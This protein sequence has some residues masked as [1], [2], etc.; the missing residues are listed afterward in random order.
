[1]TLDDFDPRNEEEQ[2]DPQPKPSWVRMRLIV[3]LC[4][5]IPLAIFGFI[6]NSQ[7]TTR[8]R[9]DRAL[10]AWDNRAALREI[11][12]FEDRF[13][14]TAETAFLQ[15]RAYRHLGDDRSFDRYSLLAYQ[16][17]YPEEKIK[18]ERMLREISVGDTDNIRDSMEMV[19]AFPGVELEEVGPA[20]MYGFLSRLD[21]SGIE[22]FLTFWSKEE[23]DS[24]WIP[25]FHGMALL[26]RR[27]VTAAIE[28][29]EKCA[30]EHPDFVPVYSQLGAAYVRAAR[31]DLGIATL[32][33]YLRKI[34][35]DPSAI[36]ALAT[37]LASQDQDQEVIDLLAPLMNATDLLDEARVSLSRV[38][39]KRRKWDK[40]I[41]ALSPLA[42]SW[43]E[44]VRAADCLSQAHQALGNDSEA[45]S[46]AKIAHDGRSELE[47]VAKR[48]TRIVNGDDMEPKQLYELGHI[49][50]HKMSREDGFYW[51]RY[52]LSIDATY[53][54]AHEDLVIFY[55]RTNQPKLAA[56]HQ[57]YID[58]QRQTQ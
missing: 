21:F 42:S 28:S 35:T 39:L 55:Q 16:L 56:R 5:L 50:L 52:T 26:A 12:Q 40:A 22:Q 54:P 14:S 6:H 18:C 48:I 43:P 47:S 17:G 36:S 27:N 8:L 53:L 11:R 9:I 38:Y 34:P 23:P 37:A 32:R 44:D 31:T 58:L 20:I 57:S 46:F 7:S 4:I 30:R 49:L 41:A 45:L 3:L 33:R 2:I 15:S 25:Y 13:G 24:P 10:D 1:M 51:L 19:M 29:F